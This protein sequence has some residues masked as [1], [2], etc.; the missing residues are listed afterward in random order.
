MPRPTSIDGQSA[1]S[2]STNYARRHAIYAVI[3]ISRADMATRASFRRAI[4]SIFPR[5]VRVRGATSIIGKTACFRFRIYSQYICHFELSCTFKDYHAGAFAMTMYV[6]RMPRELESRA[7]LRRL[8]SFA[9][10]F[11]SRRQASLPA[12]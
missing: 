8:K 6:S 12:S 2:Y 9:S 3:S 10:Y 7:K 5:Y 11:A 4:A 1:S